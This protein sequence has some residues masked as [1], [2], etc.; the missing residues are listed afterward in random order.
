VGPVDDTHAAFAKLR[1]DF[2]GSRSLAY[3]HRASLA[4][5]SPRR[6][7]RSKHARAGADRR[8]CSGEPLGPALGL[9]GSMAMD[10][11]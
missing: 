4:P 9:T 6:T 3:L 5:A 7:S 1:D 11:V 10:A 8:G 2:M